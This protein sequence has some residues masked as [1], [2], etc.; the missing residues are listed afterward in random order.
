MRLAIYVI[1]YN[2]IFELIEVST[3]QSRCVTTSDS[4]E[5]GK[6]C[7]NPFKSGHFTYFG[8]SDLFKL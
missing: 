4:P 8:K 7:I 2:S 3:Q 1:F 6:P 5:P